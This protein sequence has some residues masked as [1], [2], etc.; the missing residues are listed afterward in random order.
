MLKALRLI[1]VF[2]TVIAAFSVVGCND[3]DTF[4]QV[5]IVSVSRFP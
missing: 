2:L 4:E 3:D 1:G 5:S